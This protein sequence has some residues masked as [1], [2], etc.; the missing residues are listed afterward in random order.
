MAFL[1]ENDFLILDRDEGKIF[2]VMNGKM[3]EQPVIDVNVATVGYR[4]MLGIAV[5]KNLNKHTNVFLYYTEARKDREDE[6]C[7]ESCRTNW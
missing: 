3:L 1:G 7:I 6:R 2:R 4:G 5:S